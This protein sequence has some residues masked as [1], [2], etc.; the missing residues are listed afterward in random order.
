MGSSHSNILT[1]PLLLV[2]WLQNAK[3]DHEKSWPVN[4]LTEKNFGL[5]LKNKMAAIKL[6]IL[7]LGSSNLHKRYMAKKI[8]R[9]VICRSF[10]NKMAVKWDYPIKKTLY[11]P[12]HC[13]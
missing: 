9:I 12:Y 4:V 8:S 3:R 11:L 10:E 13:C 5:I 2:L 6:E 7:Q 1:S